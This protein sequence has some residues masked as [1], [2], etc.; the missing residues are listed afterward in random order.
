MVKIIP[1]RESGRT[2]RNPTVVTA[3]TVWYTASSRLNPRRR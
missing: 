3:L 1:F 2:S